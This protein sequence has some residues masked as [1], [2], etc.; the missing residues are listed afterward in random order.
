MNNN[1]CHSLLSSTKT[2]KPNIKTTFDPSDY[3]RFSAAA[4]MN[5]RNPSH[6]ND[7]QQSLFLNALGKLYNLGF[8]PNISTT[9]N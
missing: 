4:T 6:N 3:I 5:N 7:Q 2:S 8:N 9:M 1:H